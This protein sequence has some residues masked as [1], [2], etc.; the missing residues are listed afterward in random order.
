MTKI[1]VM[2]ANIAIDMLGGTCAAAE[3]FGITDGAVSQWREHG[4]PAARAQTLKY[5][6]PD[7]FAAA[8]RA[9]QEKASEP[10]K[11]VA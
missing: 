8:T 10:A 9:A 1:L 2:N 3:F 11:E 6:R 4:I 7:I 5:A